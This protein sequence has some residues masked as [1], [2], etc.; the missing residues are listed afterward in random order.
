MYLYQE[1]R[2][3]YVLGTSPI[4][5]EENPLK[6]PYISVCRSSRCYPSRNW[7]PIFQALEEAV[8]EAGIDVQVGTAGCLEV[9]KSGPVVFYSGD[10]TWYNR[11]TPDV[12]KE[13]VNQHLVKGEKVKHHLYPPF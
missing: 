10:R 6:R 7:K 12:A 8:E 1:L 2:E 5:F 13:I 9:C 11:V 3:I 4:H